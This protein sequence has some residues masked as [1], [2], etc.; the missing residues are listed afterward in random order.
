MLKKL[1]FPGAAL[2]LLAGAILLNPEPVRTQV[3]NGQECNGG[4]QTVP[5]FKHCWKLQ[6]GGCDWDWCI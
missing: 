6:T 1:L 4:C 2:V 3:C 5:D